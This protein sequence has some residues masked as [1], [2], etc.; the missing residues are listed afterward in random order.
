MIE[1]GQKYRTNV[2]WTAENWPAGLVLTVVDKE[3]S[4]WYGCTSDRGHTWITDYDVE[5]NLVALI[6]GSLL[7]NTI[8][9]LKCKKCGEMKDF[10]TGV[11]S[12]TRA[13]N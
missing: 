13:R 3:A 6:S 9:I 12:L 5:N 10:V 1:S 11:A 8:I 4:D 7:P 2:T